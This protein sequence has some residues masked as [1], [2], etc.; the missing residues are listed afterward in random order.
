MTVRVGEPLNIKGIRDGLLIRASSSSYTDLSQ[1]LSAGLAQKQGFLQGSRVMLQVDGQPLDA[2]QLAE[3]QA[4]FA[5]HELELWA[6]LAEDEATRAAAR[7]LGLATRLSGS[8]TDLDGNALSDS[9]AGQTPAA[10]SESSPAPGG[11]LLKET[12]RSGQSVFHE[13]HVVIIGDV[14]PGAE[15]IAG[16]DVIVWG[17]L[18]G[19]V[20]AGALGNETAVI[21]ALDLNPTQLRIAGHIAIPPDERRRKPAPEQAY[22]RNGQIVADLWQ[23]KFGD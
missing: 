2:E 13:G 18:R 5:R 19:L 3:L 11:L 14:N 7:Q 16:G 4:L 8:P 21:C 15:I 12:V 17:R 20:H 22:V 1:Q 23:T 10:E 9:A 6:I